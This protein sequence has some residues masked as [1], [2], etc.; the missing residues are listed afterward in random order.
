M[1]ILIAGAGKVGMALTNEL[2]S[3]GHDITLIDTRG[4]VLEDAIGKYDVITLEGNSA[5]KSTL[6]EA[7]IKKMD[8]FIAATNADEVNLL[9]CFTA[10]ALNENIHTIARIRVFF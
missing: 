7:G 5:S 4:K 10:H 3:E 8:L 2:S 9:S 6:E 1:K